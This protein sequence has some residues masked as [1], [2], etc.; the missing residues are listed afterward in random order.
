VDLGSEENAPAVATRLYAALRDCDELGASVIL[1][2]SMT[3]THPLSNAI[4]DR[5]RRA[6]AR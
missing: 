4:H 2:R 5:L 1:V 3:S 6:A